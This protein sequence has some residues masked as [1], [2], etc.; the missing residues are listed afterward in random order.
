MKLYI[1]RRD[2]VGKQ[3]EVV[4]LTTRMRCFS[5][6]NSDTANTVCR[7]LQSA[8]DAGQREIQQ[9]FQAL[10]NVLGRED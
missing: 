1:V 7:A 6:K 9:K 2:E 10:M 3:Y 8:Y 4:C 5:S